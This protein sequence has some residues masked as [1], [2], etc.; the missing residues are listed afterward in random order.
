MTHLCA[1]A[2]RWVFVLN[3]PKSQVSGD[4]YFA[5]KVDDRIV[6]CVADCTGHG[7]P[8]ALLSMVGYNLIHRAVNEKKFIKPN[9]I[10]AFI[11]EEM[12]FYQ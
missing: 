9:E 2:S 11:D 1:A 12:Q 4:F 10:L 8:G 7:V 6:F 3:L 5:A